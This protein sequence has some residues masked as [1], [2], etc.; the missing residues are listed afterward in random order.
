MVDA[1]ARTVVVMDEAEV[2]CE[3]EKVGVRISDRLNQKIEAEA[4]RRDADK[5]VAI[6]EICRETLED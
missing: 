6:L 1:N 2:S 4:E 3:G 5:S